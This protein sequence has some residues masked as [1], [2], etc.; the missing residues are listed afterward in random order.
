MILNELPQEIVITF[1][2]EHTMAY[3]DGVFVSKQE[4]GMEKYKQVMEH[5][6]LAKPYRSLQ[7]TKLWISEG[8]PKLFGCKILNSTINLLQWF[9]VLYPQKDKTHW[10]IEVANL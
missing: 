3:F 8:F 10:T 1:L 6:F 2:M 4:N 9:D 5:K 7:C